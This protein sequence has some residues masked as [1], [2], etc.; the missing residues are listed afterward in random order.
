MKKSIV[1]VLRM[2]VCLNLILGLAACNLP[3]RDSLPLVEPTLDTAASAWFDAPLDGMVLPPAPYEVVFHGASNA[4]VERGELSIN[5]T[6]VEVLP[7]PEIGLLLAVFHTTWSPPGPGQYALQARTQGQDGRW[8][9]YVQVNVTV[10]A[11]PTPTITL[12]P[13]RTPTLTPT[14]TTTQLPAPT[15]TVTRTE[16]PMQLVF[17]PRV[18]PDLFYTK[19]CTPDRVTITVNVSPV[20]TI[21]ALY[22]FFHLENQVGG[23]A[24]DW[25]EPVMMGKLAPGQFSS[26]LPSSII[27]G[28]NSFESAWLLLQFA[29][30]DSQGIVQG[31]S[32]VFA[33]ATLARCGLRFIPKV[34]LLPGITPLPRLSTLAPTPTPVVIK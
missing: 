1:P 23:G 33:G 25:A 11:T 19:D 15:R 4:G 18:V 26:I 8:S 9:D 17:S 3:G 34:T 30:I 7:N 22:L 10:A 6:Q 16:T 21:S 24:T 32:E 5:G 29:A 2:W 20:E 27:P 28:A 14:A 31:R 12:I 13:T